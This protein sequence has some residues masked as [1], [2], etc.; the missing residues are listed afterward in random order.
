[1]PLRHVGG[2]GDTAPY[3]TNLNIR[4]SLSFTFPNE[5]VP[6][7]LNYCHLQKVGIHSIYPLMVQQMK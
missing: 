2:S 5:T 1:M 3:L 7:Y 6:L 4:C